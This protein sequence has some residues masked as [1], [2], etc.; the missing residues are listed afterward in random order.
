MGTST[1]EIALAARARSPFS[2]RSVISPALVWLLVTT[3]VASVL[4][5]AFETRRI[6]GLLREMTDV[7]EPARTLSWQLE[8]G[9]AMEYSALQ[10]YAL[11]GDTLLL[12]QYR[13]MADDETS[14]LA[15]LERLAPRLGPGAVA[16]TA[17]V[18]HRITRWQE[19]NHV[20]FGGALSREQF[21]AAARAQRTLRD[22][23][24]SEIDRLPSRLS[25]EAATRRE[26]VQ[27]VRQCR[28]GSCGAD[29]H[30]HSRRA[31]AS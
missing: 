2:L 26:Q 6:M 9:M 17:T 22:S 10:G 28:T 16:V 1:R 4:I 14:R 8:S 18:R 31:N 11:S 25:A 7:I 29:G 15:E 30:C 23:I 27:S 13:R 24:T 21:A 5:P 12:R 3:I 19:L 20:L